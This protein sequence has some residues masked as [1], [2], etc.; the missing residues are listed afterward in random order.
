MCVWVDKCVWGFFLWGD[1]GASLAAILGSS[2]GQDICDG[3]THVS[4]LLRFTQSSILFW[5]SDLLKLHGCAL[6][7]RISLFHSNPHVGLFQKTT[8]SSKKTAD[9][10]LRWV[11]LCSCGW[12]AL[13]S[14]FNLPLRPCFPHLWITLSHPSYHHLTT[15][16]YLYVEAAAQRATDHMLSSLLS[17][18]FVSSSIMLSIPPLA[19]SLYWHIETHIC[20]W[21]NSFWLPVTTGE[22]SMSADVPIPRL[23]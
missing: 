18:P 8:G 20:R 11:L 6:L 19:L 10:S 5:A 3:W 21:R 12:P 9:N 15:I 7:F 2:W 22:W 14:A 13:Q 17:F 23:S 16:A 1:E 4:R